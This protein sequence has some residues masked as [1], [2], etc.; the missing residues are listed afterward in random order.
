MM[1]GLLVVVECTDPLASAARYVIDTFAGWLGTGVEYISRFS[2]P[3]GTPFLSYTSTDHTPEA[4]EVR[5]VAS[6]AAEQFLTARSAPYP[7]R[8]RLVRLGDGNAIDVFDDSLFW[9]RVREEGTGTVFYCDL[10]AGSFY[11]LS[12]WQEV[13]SRERDGFGRFPALA[14]LQAK[15]D[16]L[17]EP[18]VNQYFVLLEDALERKGARLRNRPSHDSFS[19]C[20]THDVDYLR[21]W[22][23]GIIYREVVRYFLQNERGAHIKART[24]RLRR[25][26]A[27][28]FPSHDPYRSSLEQLLNAERARNITA[29]YFLKTGVSDR[30]DARY[31]LGW[32]YGARLISRLKDAGH[33]I[34][35]HPSFRS[36]TDGSR[37]EREKEKLIRYAGHVDGVRQHYLRLDVPGTWRIHEALGFRYDSTG[38]FPDHEGFR[39]GF[40]GLFHPFD[41]DTWRPMRLLEIPL[42]AMDGTFQSYRH[43]TPAESLQIITRLLQKV[44]RYR[45]AAA[46]LF[47][48]TAYDSFDYD[49]WGKVFESVIDAARSEG[50]VFLPCCSLVEEWERH[51]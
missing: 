35:L 26:L 2:V 4:G 30:R 36:Y 21:K 32:G 23:A 40:A 24:S 46:L 34:G 50:A 31:S 43:L 17:H 18:V 8:S 10:I 47:H 48:N 7:V 9:G 29:T 45:G 38:G 20:L 6:R 19:V 12:G 37:I 51:R 11:F 5:V 15:F 1:M 33:E 27:S 14:S 16:L 42:M 3:S 25:F 13:F 39:F 28:S 44:K 41:L 22:T 49:G